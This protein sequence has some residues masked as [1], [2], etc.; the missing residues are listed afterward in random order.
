M[1]LIQD[2][3][4]G[5]ICWTVLDKI[6]SSTKF[7]TALNCTKLD[8]DSITESNGNPL[9]EPDANHIRMTGPKQQQQAI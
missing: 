1:H 7:F 3:R 6:K 9:Q 2:S 4:C 8:T 5:S